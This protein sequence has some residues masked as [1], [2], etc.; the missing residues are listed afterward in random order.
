MDFIISLLCVMGFTL[1]HY[2]SKYMR[3]ADKA[4]RSKFLSFS[5]GV[6]VSYVFVDLLPKLNDYQLILLDRLENSIWRHIENHIYIIAL[7]G[8]VLFYTLER[9]AKSSKNNLQLKEKT[10]ADASVFWIHM[11]AF[12]IYNAIIG[13]LLVKEQ[14]DNSY[15]I[16]FYFI[17]LS[18]HFITNDWSLRRDHIKVYDQYARYLLAIAPIFGWLVGVLTEVN[19]FVLS[20]LQ[21]F[22]IGGIILNAL[23]EELPEEK[24]SS[25]TSFLL[26]VIGYT[27]LLLLI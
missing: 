7:V 13:Y 19:E 25:L 22:I 20:I 21:A 11:S 15:G 14:F 6:A 4:P 16:F 2:S 12:F 26:G 9:L 8:L 24:E 1:I 17:A 3:F 27:L 10:K 18:V 23:K 5:G